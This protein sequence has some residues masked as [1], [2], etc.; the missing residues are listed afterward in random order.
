MRPQ[1]KENGVTRSIRKGRK[2][3]VAFGS[4][5]PLAVFVGVGTSPAFVP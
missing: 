2:Q 5:A 4:T 1:M 3:A